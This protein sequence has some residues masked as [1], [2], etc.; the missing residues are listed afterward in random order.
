MTTATARV[1]VLLALVVTVVNGCGRQILG[2][3]GSDDGVLLIRHNEPN[4][5]EIVDVEG[6]T[7]LCCELGH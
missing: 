2:F 7:V 6:R 5:V 3:G 1:V 4:P